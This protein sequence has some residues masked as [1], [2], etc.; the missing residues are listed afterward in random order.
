MQE[1]ILNIDVSC[2]ANYDSPANPR[3]VN[4]LK[5]LISSKYAD[6]VNTIRNIDDKESRDKIKATLP[7]IT[8]SGLFTYRAKNCL[9]RHSGFIQFDIDLKGNEAITNY[10]NLKKELC[11]I[12][13]VAY[14]GLSVSGK[15]FWGL[16]PIVQAEKHNQYF[17]FI[18][19]WFK[20]IGLIIDPAPKSVSSLRGY[21]YDPHGYFNHAAKPLKEFC[22]EPVKKATPLIT[23]SNKGSNVLQ[24]ATKFAEGNVGSFQEGN[25][26]N[27]IFHF[28]CYLCYR[29]IDRLEAENWIDKNLLPVTEIKSNCISYPFENY[30][31]G[32]TKPIEQSGPVKP[33]PKERPDIE[34]VNPSTPA[35]PRRQIILKEPQRS[36]DWTTEINEIETFFVSLTLHGPIVLSQCVNVI[37]IPRFITSHLATLKAN[38]G[39][40]T[41]QPHRERLNE[42]KNLFENNKYLQQ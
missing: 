12:S 33:Q 8:P 38:N 23:F 1:S 37:D 24:Y 14:C 40:K 25:R 39:N 5:W 6:L 30:K 7:A 20:A 32:E 26:H 3:P 2:F 4:L 42:L 17:K 35:Q 19:N 22:I 16:I 34:P 21:A 36:Q 41:F 15:G 10:S 18:E 27:Y 11:K 28:C 29:G 9:V 31:V 13:Q